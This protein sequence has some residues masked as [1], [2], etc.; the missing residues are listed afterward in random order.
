MGVT[1]DYTLNIEG[2]FANVINRMQHKID[3][4]VDKALD[5][6]FQTIKADLQGIYQNAVA[7]FYSSYSPSFYGR[8][9]SL[10]NLIQF[11]EN[12]DE[13]KW[14]FDPGSATSMRAGG[15]VYELAF[16]QGYHGGATGTD[17]RGESRGVPSY[18]TPFPGNFIMSADGEG[19]DSS[20]FMNG[21]T[22]WGRAAVQSTP[23]L[24]IWKRELET[25]KGGLRQMFIS[26]LQSHIGSIQWF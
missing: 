14:E 23:P 13:V 9:G 2:F 7:E 25:Y 6:L 5:E 18:R 12:K 20:T 10:Y 17:K 1:F 22:R 16:R 24:E 26:I 21:F 3:A 19:Y 15:T 4:A 11:S 8:T